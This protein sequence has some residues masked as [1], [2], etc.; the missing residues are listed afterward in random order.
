[1]ITIYPLEEVVQAFA[2]HKKGKDVKI[3]LK[4]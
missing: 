2:A 1:M 4:P 3:M